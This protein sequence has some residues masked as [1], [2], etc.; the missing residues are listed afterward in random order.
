M[1]SIVETFVYLSETV[2]RDELVLRTATHTYIDEELVF[3][4]LV[5]QK[6]HIV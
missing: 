2:F 5:R 3:S 1:T 6:W 4:F